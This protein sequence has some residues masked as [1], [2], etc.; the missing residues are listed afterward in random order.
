MPPSRLPEGTAYHLPDEVR[1]RER[2]L[3]RLSSLFEAWGYEPVGLP[4]LEHYDPAHPA[5]RESFKLVDADNSLLALRSDFTPALAGLVR[6]HDRQAA[7]GAASLR[8]HYRGR[9]WRAREADLAHARE[10]T[11]V[12]IELIGVSNAR[13]DTELIHLARESVRAVGLTPRIEIGNPA[14]VRAMFDEAGVPASRREALAS[15]IDRKDAAML[16]ALLDELNPSGEHRRALRLIPDLYGGREVLEQAREALRFESV[17]GELARV[18]AI[19]DQFEDQS[20]L[21]LDLGVA[22][23]LSYYTGVTFRAYTFDFGQPLLGGGRYDGALLPFAAGFTLGLERLISAGMARAEA[24]SAPLV[25]CSD[26]AAARL[27][28]AAGWRVLRSLSLDE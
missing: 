28:R 2:V 20:E 21:L 26:D 11:Q 18:E 3:A 14:L 9:A 1:L 6:Q 25:I 5:A 8:L 7:A 10:F 12:G 23:R 15:A 19:L 4:A 13:A 24:E 16:D 22:R 27:L 17:L